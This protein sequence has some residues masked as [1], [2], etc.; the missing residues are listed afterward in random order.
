L[1]TVTSPYIKRPMVSL[2][3][4]LQLHVEGHAANSIQP[5]GVVSLTV[6]VKTAMLTT[7]A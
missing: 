4:E 2:H 6:L 7:E 1:T 5:Y 3:V